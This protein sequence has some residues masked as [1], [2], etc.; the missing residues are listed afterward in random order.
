MRL[1][2]R[3]DNLVA[4]DDI[5]TAWCRSLTLAE[6]SER[7]DREEVP[8]SKVYSIADVQADPHFRERGATIELMDPVLGAIPAPAAVTRFVGR[9]EPVRPWARTPGSS[10][11]RC[12]GSWGLERRSWMR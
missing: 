9:T 7:L 11:H 6:L 10:T 1:V 8:F 3:T 2:L 4:I 12:I 5:V